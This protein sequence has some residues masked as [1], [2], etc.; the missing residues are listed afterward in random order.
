MT[1]VR[2][3]RERGWLWID[4]SVLERYGAE[5]GPYG[6]AVYVTLAYRANGHTQKCWPGRADI[7]RLIGISAKQVSREVAKLEQLGLIGVERRWKPGD[8]DQDT[9]VYTLL[10]VSGE[11]RDRESLGTGSP[12]EVGTESPYLGT[13]SPTN[14]NHEQH[15]SSTTTLPDAADQEDLPTTLL[16]EE[17]VDALRSIGFRNRKLEQ[18]LAQMHAVDPR[19]ALAYVVWAQDEG[20]RPAAF[21]AQALIEGWEPPPVTPERGEA[22][23]GCELCGGYGRLRTEDGGWGDPCLCTTVGH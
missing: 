1:E 9:N 5:L 13:G 15:P 6:I 7:A 14:N 20:E 12:A 8:Q 18:K 16:P 19:R 17:L 11:G 10:S 23:P 22:D 21:L 3:I 4:N 2:D